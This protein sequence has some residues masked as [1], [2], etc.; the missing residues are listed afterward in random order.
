MKKILL[1][2]AEGYFVVIGYSLYRHAIFDYEKSD[3]YSVL[4]RNLS[5]SAWSVLC[6]IQVQNKRKYDWRL[7]NH[8]IGVWDESCSIT[9][10]KLGQS[11]LYCLV[12]SL[13]M[14]LELV[15]DV[16]QNKILRGLTGVLIYLH[17]FIIFDDIYLTL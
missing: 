1:E 5:N 12:Y 8:Q 14:R 7:M 16:K 17:D 13:S 3:Q 9:T 2:F 11:L 4:S 6:R 15:A 10:K